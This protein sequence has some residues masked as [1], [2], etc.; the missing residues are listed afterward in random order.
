[1]KTIQNSQILF[2]EWWKSTNR[3]GKVRDYVKFCE[4]VDLLRPA[5]LEEIEPGKKLWR[6]SM[7]KPNEFYETMFRP[8]VSW[9]TITDIFKTK[10][11]YIERASIEYVEEP[12]EGEGSGDSKPTKH[13]VQRSLFDS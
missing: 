7:V 3:G 9:F 12:S 5:L 13:N 8:E 4:G 6:Q 2:K 1:M 10:T 11:I